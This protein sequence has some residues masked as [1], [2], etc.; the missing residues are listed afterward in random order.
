MG[1]VS[2]GRSQSSSSSS[3]SSRGAWGPWCPTKGMSSWAWLLATAVLLS[4]L[5][6]SVARPPL[7]G[8]KEDEEATLEPQE[9][10]TKY[11]ISKPTL[12]S[13]HPGE[14][15]RL[16]CPLPGAGPV[17][18]TKDG[19][20]LGANNRT[21][22]EQEVLQIR[23]TTPRDSGL[24]ACTSVGR[25]TV[26]F[27]V[28]VTDAISSGD[29]EDDTERS[30]D[31][32]ADGEQI[33]KYGRTS[34]RQTA[35]RLLTRKRVARASCPP[36]AR[37]PRPRTHPGP[38]RMLADCSGEQTSPGHQEHSQLLTSHMDQHLAT[39]Q[40]T[41]TSASLGLCSFYGG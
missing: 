34:P 31:G 21:L 3:S 41:A 6:V 1:S 19:A 4:L 29:D 16:S 11:Q 24:Y 38:D 12:C 33:S 8:A 27:I 10:A 40:N 25:D 26:C 17:T 20:S 36:A 23:D 37:L 22:I 7:T 32:G 2:R 9:A 14:V 28:N 18:W 30:E 13:L 35:S 15:L 5:V 39:S